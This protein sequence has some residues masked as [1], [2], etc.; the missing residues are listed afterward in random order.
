MEFFFDSSAI[1]S[2]RGGSGGGRGGSSGGYS[3]GYSSSSGS[4]KSSYSGG[5]LLPMWFYS[6]SSS[7]GTGED[8][9]ATWVWIVLAVIIMLIIGCCCYCVMMK[10]RGETN[11]KV[12]VNKDSDFEAAVSEARRNIA[13]ASPSFSSYDVKY[14]TYGGTFDSK[15]SDRG[16]TLTA[17]LTLRI[18]ND[19]TGGYEIGG[20]GS[21]A[22]GITKVT[23]GYITYDGRAWWLEEAFSGKDTG[24]KILSKGT[25][26][27]ADNTFSGTWRSSSENQG[28]YVSFVGRDI[29]KTIASCN[30]EEGIP[31]VE[32]EVEENLPIAF[33]IA[34]APVMATPQVSIKTSALHKSISWFD[35]TIR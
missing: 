11:T 25:F 20:E 27:F 33:A 6:S 4:Y 28:D 35:S 19:G 18:V 3:G 2:L 13:Y 10:S 21:D 7:N 8:K 23:D 32:A 26:H 9:I 16:R 15:Y 34:D 12:D 30:G 29:T 14:Q 1:R 31:T 5:R 22:D 17:V 24:L